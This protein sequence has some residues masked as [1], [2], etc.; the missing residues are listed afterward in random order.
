M[1]RRRNIIP[2]EAKDEIA[3]VFELFDADKSGCVDR[4][5]LFV[6]LRA[7]GFNVTKEDIEQI[8][9]EKDV[10]NLGYLVFK[11]FR[12][13]IAEKLSQR[14]PEEEFKQV[15]VLFDKEHTG[16]IGIRE[17]KRVCQELGK[18]DLSEDDM[19]AMISQF[20]TDG[21]GYVTQSEFIAMM[22]GDF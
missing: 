8:F 9:R 19:R 20:D 11:Q 4:Q 16:R 13:V 3:E 21:D 18:T 12:E 15:F 7:M 1:S 2:Q 17:I 14:K 22:N 5:E 6:G 10:E